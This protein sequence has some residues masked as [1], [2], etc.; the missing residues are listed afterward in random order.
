MK[1]IF[2]KITNKY[3][4]KLSILLILI[5][6]SSCQDYA[7]HEADDYGQYQTET[8]TIKPFSESASCEIDTSDVEKS[9]YSKFK[10]RK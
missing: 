6:T 4:K 3:I 1:D 10:Y 7:C 9:K 8:L 5:I 2:T